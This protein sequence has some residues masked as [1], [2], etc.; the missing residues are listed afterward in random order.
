MYNRHIVLSMDVKRKRKKQKNTDHRKT[1]QKHPSCKQSLFDKLVSW[2]REFI[3]LQIVCNTRYK[4]CLLLFSKITPHFS[5]SITVALR[6]G[7]CNTSWRVAYISQNALKYDLL[8][9]CINIST[10][11]LP[12]HLQLLK[13]LCYIQ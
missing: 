4:L 3:K 9:G 2:H 13:H 8:N 7:A 6:T 5:L 10:E 12:L 1:K 11:L